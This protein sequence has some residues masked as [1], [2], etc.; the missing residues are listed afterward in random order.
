MTTAYQAAQF[1][2]LE[3][4]VFQRLDET[5]QVTNT[6]SQQNTAQWLVAM[7]LTYTCDKHVACIGNCIKVASISVRCGKHSVQL[8]V[9]CL[10][11]LARTVC[12]SSS[13]LLCTLLFMQ[14]LTQRPH[15]KREHI[16]CMPLWAICMLAKGVNPMYML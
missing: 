11:V 5:A 9:E 14:P 2:W 16:I 7:A 10:P 1:I 6:L 3:R 15:H 12:L 13:H 4:C 8:G